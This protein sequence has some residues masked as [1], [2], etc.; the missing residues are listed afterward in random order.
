MQKVKLSFFGLG[1]VGL[2]TAAC[3]SYKGFKVTCFDIDNEKVKTINNGKAPFFEPGLDELLKVSI[4][5]G[6]LKAV[7]DP[8]KAVLDSKITFI[9]VS[10]PNKEDGSIDLTSVKDASERIG[11]ALRIKDRWHLI[12]I[13]STVI[14]TTTEKI[15]GKIIEEHSG[16]RIGRDFGLCANP[17][18]LKEGSAVEDTFKPD[19]IVI[20]ESDKKSGDLLESFYKDFYGE[21]LPPILRTN[22]VNAE[23]IKYVNNSFLAMKVS[24]IN[25]VANLCQKIRGADVEIIA[26]GI[27]LDRRIGEL[28]LKAGAGWGG[29]CFEK[30][31]KALLNF[32]AKNSVE[33]PLIESTLK[34][35]DTQ[36]YKLIDLAKKLVGE[37][38]GKRISVLGLSF[39]PNTDD[40]RYAVSIKI[41]N[42]L[43]E[44]DAKVVVYDPI[45]MQNAR[46]IFNNTVEYANSV[47]ECLKGSECALIVTEWNDFKGLIPE[48][49]IK[50][51]KNPVVVD[52]RRMYDSKAFSSKLKFAAIG[53]GRE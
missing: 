28:F 1:Y 13:K 36:P 15:V 10:T 41:V 4:E 11:E 25:M 37:L 33:L 3:F 47:E 45:A 17:E 9:T 46:K 52:G 42:K 22:L 24:F 29:S 14:P 49:F 2:T 23:L 5:K 35:N 51:M 32:G 12:V 27:G 19:R 38:K 16:K 20:G 6:F 26:K 43:L 18:F 40:M 34:V 31:L 44:E 50:L 7:E 39:K 8:V 30:D 48:D 21:N 53:L